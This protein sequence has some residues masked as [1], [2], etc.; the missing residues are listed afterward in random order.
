[1]TKKQLKAMPVISMNY[2][3]QTYY[4]LTEEQALVFSAH[5]HKTL[6][7]VARLFGVKLAKMSFEEVTREYV[8]TG[9]VILVEDY[10]GN[11]APYINP[12]QILEDEYSTDM[13]ER[14]TSYEV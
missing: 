9:K 10:F 7:T 11:I 2:F 3:L 12:Y 14:Y 6:K 5:T 13:D 8:L 4:G 1:M